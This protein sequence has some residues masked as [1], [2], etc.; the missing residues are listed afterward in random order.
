MRDI[1]NLEESLRKRLEA[2][3]NRNIVVGKLVT[4][5]ENTAEVLE[6]IVANQ[7][8]YIALVKKRGTMEDEIAIANLKDE[9]AKVEQTT[10]NLYDGKDK[11][12]NESAELE[13]EIA[14]LQDEINDGARQAT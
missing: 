9:M 13:H 10:A 3:E 14:K 1:K 5:R 6:Q 12:E 7:E 8:L 11:L 2:R 4:L